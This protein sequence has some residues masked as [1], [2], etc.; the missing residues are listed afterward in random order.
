[1]NVAVVAAGATLGIACTCYAKT[2]APAVCEVGR[3]AEPEP[4]PE[5]HEQ[6][7]HAEAT[8]RRKPEP[9]QAA[10]YF[11]SDFPYSSVI[12]EGAAAVRSH[13]AF[14]PE[15][16]RAQLEAQAAARWDEFYHRHAAGFFKPRNYL[17]HCFPE[18]AAAEEVPSAEPK[19]GCRT[20][21]EVGCGAG[22]TA[23][24]LL[25]LN[26]SL[27]V[28]ACDFS[29]AAVA[30]TKVCVRARVRACVSHT[31]VSSSHFLIHKTDTSVVA[32]RP[33][34]SMRSTLRQVVARP[35]FGT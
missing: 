21:L 16:R 25:E 2:G 6:R 3:R 31:S 4:E 20:V 33:A 14:L 1:M 18:L 28:L 10:Q 12:E 27:H 32:N 22:D 9:K 23:F 13:G 5:L 29:A 19:G 24:S 8:A 17:L 15:A 26:P 35:S 30:T 11:D 34:R 7:A